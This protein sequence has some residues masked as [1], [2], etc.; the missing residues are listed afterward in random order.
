MSWSTGRGQGAYLN[1]A[2][3][4]EEAVQ[5][6][7]SKASAAGLVEDD[8]GNATALRVGSIGQ[9]HLLDTT[10][11]LSKVFLCWEE[12]MLVIQRVVR[13]K[14]KSDIRNPAAGGTAEGTQD[15][16][17]EIVAVSKQA[18]SAEEPSIVHRKMPPELEL[19]GDFSTQGSIA[20]SE[21]AKRPK[22]M[23]GEL[24][25]NQ[26]WHQTPIPPFHAAPHGSTHGM[27]CDW[28]PGEA[29]I[30]VCHVPGF[31]VAHCPACCSSI[32]SCRNRTARM[33]ITIE[34]TDSEGALV[35]LAPC[36]SCVA[37]SRNV[38]PTGADQATR[39]IQGGSTRRH[40]YSAS[41]LPID[42]AT[43]FQVIEL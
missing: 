16:G 3:V 15:H 33:R 26:N 28:I 17:R 8:V 25:L 7:E 43:V 42:L 23:V 32:V 40:G 31:A 4:N 39:L 5:L 30:T 35:C 38:S 6:L 9:L 18:V 41:R 10:N 34:G 36:L 20:P 37:G 21:T 29:T 22:T 2:V 27:A 1:R 14:T 11:S 19:K 12:A 13:R 24:W